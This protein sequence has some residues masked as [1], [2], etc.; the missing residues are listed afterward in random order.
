[1]KKALIIG[2]GFGQAVYLPVLTELDYEVITVDMDT[3]KGA[4][5]SSIEDAIRVHSKFDTVIFV[6]QTLHISSWQEKLPHLVRLFLSKSPVSLPVT[7][8]NNYVLIIHLHVL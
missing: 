2:L 6:H 4:D 8:G 5:F 7:H 3:S 1:M